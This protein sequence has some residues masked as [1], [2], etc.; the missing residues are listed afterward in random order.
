MDIEQSHVEKFAA[1]CA[2]AILTFLDSGEPQWVTW[3]GHSH[4][5]DFLSVELDPPIIPVVLSIEEGWDQIGDFGEITDPS[6][7]HF[8][9]EA[10]RDAIL[11]LLT[12]EGLG[13]RLLKRFLT[14]LEKLEEESDEDEGDAPEPEEQ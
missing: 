10:L 8:D 13:E 1:V 7:E 6:H 4:R 2:E 5:F 9:P 3:D 12:E 11:Q 14:R